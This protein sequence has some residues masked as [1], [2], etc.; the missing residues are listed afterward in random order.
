MSA[1]VGIIDRVLR[2]LLG[3]VLIGAPL[4]DLMGL[5]ASS[6][7]AYVMI[8]VG[9]ILALTAVVGVCPLYSALG[10]STKA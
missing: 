8:V 9:A 3:A 1:N 7:V 5:G 2:L 4:I 6:T 10:L